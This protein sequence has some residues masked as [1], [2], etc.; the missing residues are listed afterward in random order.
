[1]DY[2]KA[3]EEVKASWE[4]ILN[5]ITSPA[6]RT[7]NG[8][9]SYICP[10]C[11]HGQGGDGLTLN[12]KSGD[13]YSLKCF[14]GTCNFS[15]DI[16]ALVGEVDQLTEFPDQLRQAGRYAGIEIEG[17]Y[18]S[19]KT[20]QKQPENERKYTDTAMNI[21]TKKEK[22]ESLLPYIEECRKRLTET[23]YHRQRG[24]SDEVA[25]RF[26]LGYDPVYK[27]GRDT[28]W[29][30]LIIPTG[31]YSYTARN[32]DPQA[33]DRY[34]NKGESLPFN[35]E[36]LE[37]AQ[38]PIFIVEGEIDALSIIEAGGEAVALGSTSNV[39]KLIKQYL[40]KHKPEH[41]LIISLDNDEAGQTATEKL[42]TALEELGISFYR[43]NPAGQYKDAN[44]ALLADRDAFADTVDQMIRRALELEEEEL[45]AKREEYLKTSSAYHLQDFINGITESANT[46]ALPTGFSKLDQ[47]L[48]GGL[49][50]GLYL[51]GAISSLG[52]TTLIL[53]IGDQIAQQGTDVLI[54]SLE[55]ARTELMSK[56]IS[57]HTLLEVM[58][59]PNGSIKN[60]KTN[61]GI[62]D[63]ARYKKYS[64]EEIALINKAILSYQEYADHLFIHEGI[65]DI[66]TDYI[67][68]TIR[69]HQQFT[70]KTP[71][72]IVDY[73]QILAPSDVRAT[74][75][76]NMDK[77]VLELKRISRDFKTPV[78]GI[79]SFNRSNYKEEVNMTA[80]KES[81]A[82]EYGA[83]ILIGLQLKGAGKK[84]FDADEAKAKDPREIELKILKNRN[85]KISKDPLQYNY[86]PLFNYFKEV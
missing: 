64:Q 3:K 73:V 75:K 83:D 34:R 62:T 74:D 26:R 33:E 63:G 30:A 12:P 58:E 69:K 10:I 49:Y 8:R 61:R 6:K 80:Y 29:K 77:A 39:N 76:Q 82:L 28:I 17:E 59:D 45:E 67:R 66:G 70:G 51:V 41:G 81:G 19:M 79:S 43:L 11:H 46:P 5:Q 36:A 20:A 21:H 31:D 56:S 53:Q 65:G 84:E 71:V 2:D 9:T 32:T 47:L 78:I 42:E 72:I 13:K 60:A 48:D 86:Y 55:M 23:D 7:V 16:I 54:F 52:K 18:K 40:E 57:R 44:E 24:I 14:G 22:K 68:E 27:I 35:T 85:G 4:V 15:G 1:M 38:Q 37:T 50:E 25:K